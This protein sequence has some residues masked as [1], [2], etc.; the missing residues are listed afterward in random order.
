[1]KINIIQKFLRIRCF[2]FNRRKRSENHH[3]EIAEDPYKISQ[4]RCCTFVLRF[5][6]PETQ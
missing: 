3:E 5:K 4:K 2:V 6:N 1:M